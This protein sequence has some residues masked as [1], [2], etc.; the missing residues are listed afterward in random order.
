MLGKLLYV[1]KWAVKYSKKNL[2][3]N[4]VVA[5]EILEK[6]MILVRGSDL[7]VS[8]YMTDIGLKLQIDGI[9][10]LVSHFL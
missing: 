7:Q 9:I 4:G 5:R 1:E 3:E 8:T 2:E 10:K 6:F